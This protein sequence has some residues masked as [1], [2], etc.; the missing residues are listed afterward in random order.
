MQLAANAGLLHCNASNRMRMQA[1]ALTERAKAPGTLTKP[2]RA[3]V[4]CSAVQVPEREMQLAAKR[5]AR[6]WL[7]SGR[8]C[9]ASGAR[10]G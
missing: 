7:A 6:I 10:Q 5:Q 1:F 9:C 3:G 2:F 8:L 4:Q